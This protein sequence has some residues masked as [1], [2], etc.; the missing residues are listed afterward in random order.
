MISLLIHLFIFQKLNLDYITQ[1]HFKHTQAVFISN[2]S[3]SDKLKLNDYNK[4]RRIFADI[5]WMSV[6]I[7][8]Y[9]SYPFLLPPCRLQRRVSI[10]THTRLNVQ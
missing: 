3:Q 9:T 7:T 10:P 5:W 4:S 2:S 6:L 8:L 1:D